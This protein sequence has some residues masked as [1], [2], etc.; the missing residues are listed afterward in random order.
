MAAVKTALVAGVGPKLGLGAAL[1]RRFAAEGLTVIIAGRSPDK[2]SLVADDINAAGGQVI[3]VPADA[4]D[5][6]GIRR[7]FQATTAEGMRLDI[8]VYNVDSNQSAPLLDT[9]LEHFTALWRQNTLGAFL[10]ARE[11][12]RSMLPQGRG[13]VIFTGATASMRARPPFTGF[14]AAKAGVRAIAQGMAR[15]FGPRG[16]HVAHVVIDGV[17]DGDRARRQFSQYVD[18]KGK[19]GL[20]HPDAIAESY[21]HLHSQHPSAW[22]HEID[23]RPFKEPF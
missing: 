4:T 23:L 2:L 16:L 17:I 10:F 14:A 1:A 9:T 3:P 6:D 21:W 12:A 13:T 18:S 8:A 19:D 5:E 15:E 7:I 11:A 20:L 22:S